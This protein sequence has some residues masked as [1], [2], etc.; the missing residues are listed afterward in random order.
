MKMT[1]LKYPVTEL[2]HHRTP[3]LDRILSQFNPVKFFPKLFLIKH[4]Y[5]IH[6]PAPRS[7]V[8]ATFVYTRSLSRVYNITCPF[9]YSRF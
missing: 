4:H 8:E 3:L 2:S 1:M 9:H 7:V 6:A 5:I